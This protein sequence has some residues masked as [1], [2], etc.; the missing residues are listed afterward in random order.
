MTYSES[1]QGV[2]ISKARAYNLV[3]VEHQIDKSEWHDCCM[4]LVGMPNTKLDE[5]G[6]IVSVDAGDVLAWLGY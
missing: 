1:A 2:T 5:E 3:T 4:Y 6:H